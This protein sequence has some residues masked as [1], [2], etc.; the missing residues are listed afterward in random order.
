MPLQ[1][2]ASGTI[3]IRGG[4]FRIE[5]GQN[6]NSSN[7]GDKAETIQ[8]YD[9]ALVVT[10]RIGGFDVKQ[11]LVDQGSAVEIMYLDLYKRLNLK[12]KDL[13]AYVSP[14]ISF[15]GKTVISKG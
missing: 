1:G 14:L 12:S 3:I 13:T 8:P 7:F 15:E 11:V 9:D 2:N 4:C 5:K 10:V 6:T